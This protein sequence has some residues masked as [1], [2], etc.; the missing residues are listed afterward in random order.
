[1]VEFSNNPGQAAKQLAATNAERRSGKREHPALSE[2][3]GTA[4][5]GFAALMSLGLV[6][7]LV[8]AG[9]FLLMRGAHAQTA[10]DIV[11]R[12]LGQLMLANANCSA[13]A[14]G[15]Q[16]VVKG[17]Q[18]TIDDLKKQLATTKLKDDPNP[19]VTRTPAADAPVEAPK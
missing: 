2:L 6:A 13:Q 7:L 9:L 17:M 19:V 11:Q 3:D 4:K 16:S 12:Q 18:G 1:M 5:L 8:A 10:E 15:L 14:T